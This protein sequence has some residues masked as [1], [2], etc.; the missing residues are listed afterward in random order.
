MIFEDS[1][2]D[3]VSTRTLSST[4]FS[5]CTV[6]AI[7]SSVSSD[8]WQAASKPSATRTRDAIRDRARSACSSRAPART[9]TPVVPSP[10]SSSCD[11]LNSTSK[12]RDL[13]LDRHLIEDRRA[14]VRD[15]HVAV[16][17]DHHLVHALGAQ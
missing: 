5:K 14:V 3:A 1:V 15:G 6:S 11:W 7:F 13:V 10:I 12:P 8:T 4:F 2:V 16:G 17:R 9:T